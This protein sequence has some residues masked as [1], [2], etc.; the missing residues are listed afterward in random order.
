MTAPVFASHY[1]FLD[2]SNK[3]NSK[4]CDCKSGVGNEFQS[5][6]FHFIEVNLAN[7]TFGITVSEIIW[8]I[9]I[10][11]IIASIVY[12]I[13][14]KF[15]ILKCCRDYRRG[16]RRE[17]DVEMSDL[18]TYSAKKRN[19]LVKKLRSMGPR[20][21]RIVLQEFENCEK[22][23]PPVIVHVAEG[24]RVESSNCEQE[25][26]DA[27]RERVFPSKTPWQDKN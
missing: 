11:L 3:P 24:V 26:R 4:M 2:S 14:K 17:V 13:F 12:L 21:R 9:V 20:E 25:E 5:S 16:G 19:K 8:S 7:T 23:N 10:I 27:N 15:D 1:S 22:D 18:S 6:G